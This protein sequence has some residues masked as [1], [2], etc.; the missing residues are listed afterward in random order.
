MRTPP[1]GPLW[2]GFVV[3]FMDVMPAAA[4]D[5]VDFISNSPKD[6]DSTLDFTVYRIPRFGGAVVAILTNVARVKSPPANIWYT[7]SMIQANVSVR[8][9]E[10]ADWTQP[11]VREL[12]NDVRAFAEIIENGV[13]PSLYINYVGQNQ[14]VLPGY[15]NEN[16]R[17]MREAATKYDLNGAFQRLCPGGF[18][19][20]AIKD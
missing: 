4:K 17:R 12:I 16:A 14:Q 7:L 5:I 10:L 18:K 20:T 1:S 11:R 9:Q 2:G 8:T 13:C 15:G 19:I 6:P 3:R